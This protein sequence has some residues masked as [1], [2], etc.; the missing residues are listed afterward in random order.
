[1]R[2]GAVLGLG[3]LVLGAGEGARRL[4]GAAW[5]AFTRYDTPFALA[6]EDPPAGPA[7]VDRVV[8]LL[9]DGL[10]FGAS[11]GLPFLRELAG[12]GA[13]LE[14]R[15][16]LP[17]FS[18]PG[19][20]TL[21]SGAWPEVH[22]QAT[23][24]N[25]RPLAVEHLF[26][27]AHRARRRSGLVSGPEAAR[28]WGPFLDRCLTFDEEPAGR[29][30]GRLQ[31]QLGPRAEAGGRLLADSGLSLVVVELVTVDGAGHAWGGAS[32]EYARAAR[33][34]DEAARRLASGVDLTRSVLV[35]TAD[36]GHTPRGGHGGPEEAVRRVPLVMA[37]GPTRPGTRAS[38]PAVD[39]APTLAAL[40]GLPT[41]AST[42]G[43]V[44]DELLDWPAGRREAALAAAARQHER[45]RA[46]Y[47]RVVG[48]PRLSVEE[49]RAAR[50]LRERRERS[51]QVAV[52][53]LL[54][55]ALVLLLWRAGRGRDVLAGA[56]L[57]SVGFLLYRASFPL[58][59]LGYSMSLM[60]ED[61]DLDRFLLL[62]MAA[63]VLAGAVA[64][65]LG[66]V[67]DRR[68]RPRRSDAA[69]L[70]GLAVAGFLA[71]LAGRVAAAYLEA[72]LLLRWAMPDVTVAFAFYL[73]VTAAMAL[74]FAGPPLMAGAWALAGAWR[75]RPPGV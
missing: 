52:A 14:V 25:P 44:R 8:V 13:D 21:M 30:L 73:D 42:Q 40:L 66:L 6:G 70:A 22:G 4:A 17:S 37:G 59:G 45:F 12:R 49:A 63:A 71:I 11:R 15:V 35:V 64:V 3:L 53:G 57:G 60:N 26:A 54:A 46:H 18:L 31:R 48:E 74:G 16:G 33:L 61:E 5:T 34:V 69:R 23:N 50:L 56:L 19:R 68:R 29:D 47:R 36:H 43:R 10:G 55:L 65:V 75:G 24:F 58:L 62:D 28:L 39:V 51:A 2:D 41:P 7:L 72:G 32:A 9:V 67:V 27:L 20:A 38:V 1:V